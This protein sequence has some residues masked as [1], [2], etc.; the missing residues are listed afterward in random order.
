MPVDKHA[1]FCSAAHHARQFCLLLI[2]PQGLMLQASVLLCSCLSTSRQK[3]QALNTVPNLFRSFQW[4]ISQQLINT[5][6]FLSVHP[7]GQ[8]REKHSTYPT[9]SVNSY[10][11]G[12]HL[13]L[14]TICKRL[15]ALHIACTVTLLLPS[16][17]ACQ[18]A[19]NSRAPSC[20]P[21]TTHSI[22]TPDFVS[23]LHTDFRSRCKCRRMLASWVTVLLNS[24]KVALP[25][26][27]QP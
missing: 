7:M 3:T 9:T 5:P 14:T 19:C 10:A 24:L 18:S 23:M 16:N 21:S 25:L 26:P 15:A 27:V 11:P 13:P 12:S 22:L 4:D 1:K 8:C 20:T 6:C 17:I 2:R